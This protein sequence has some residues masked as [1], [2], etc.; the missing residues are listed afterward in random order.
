MD[1]L[2]ARN[3]GT[4]FEIDSV[5]GFTKRYV[6]LSEDVGAISV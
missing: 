4:Y 3:S 2:G 5:Y 6:M 1:G